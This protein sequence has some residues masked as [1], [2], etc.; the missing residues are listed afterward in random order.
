MF[1]LGM[2]III[3]I[4]FIMVIA[5]EIGYKKY[6]SKELSSVYMALMFFV[7]IIGFIFIFANIDSTRSMFEPHDT[8]YECRQ[9][10]P[11]AIDC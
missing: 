1:A 5:I 11:F 2:I 8:D 6:L 7:F 4:S 3:V 10:G 9:S